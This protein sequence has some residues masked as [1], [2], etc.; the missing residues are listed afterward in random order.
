MSDQ[1]KTCQRCGRPI[2]FAVNRKSGRTVALNPRAT[3]VYFVDEQGRVDWSE[4]RVT[5]RPGYIAHQYTC[6]GSS[7]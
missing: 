3:V 1:T 5:G 6:D 7:A 4:P 2:L